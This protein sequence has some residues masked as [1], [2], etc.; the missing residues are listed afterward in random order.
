MG[1]SLFD[2]GFK[3]TRIFD[4]EIRSIFCGVAIDTADYK[5]LISYFLAK[6][7]TGNILEHAECR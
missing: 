2:Y 7:A 4:Y 3:I 1:Q 6:K 5:N